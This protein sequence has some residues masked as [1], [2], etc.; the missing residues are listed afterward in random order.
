MFKQVPMMRLFLAKDRLAL[1][2]AIILAYQ[3]GKMSEDAF[4]LLLSCLPGGQ[5][6]VEK[7]H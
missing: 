6:A 1:P 4:Y 5:S 3:T 7:R 2:G